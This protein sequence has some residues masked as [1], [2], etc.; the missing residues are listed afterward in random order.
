MKGI[1]PMKPRAGG[2]EWISVSDIM[3]GLM[4][5]FLVV[6]VFFMRQIQQD[7]RAIEEIAIVYD[8][9]R[10]AL[11]ESLFA[12]FRDS[13][14]SWGAEI[15]STTL[16][17]KFG[18]EV[19]FRQGE[20]EI[21]PRFKE[22]LDDFFPRYVAILMQPSFRDHIEE[23]RIEGHTSS[24]W[25]YRGAVRGSGLE[26]YEG[27]MD[28]SQ[29]RTRAVLSYVVR[30]AGVREHWEG[31]LRPLMTANGLSSSQLVRNEDGGE[32]RL[33]SRRVEFRVRTDAERR[34]VEILSMTDRAR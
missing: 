14:A 9:V 8:R 18:P 23:V 5:I 21:Q 6:A 1:I 29:Q 15:D 26:A 27:N 10:D 30:L 17:V 19:L 20:A 32:N 31:W 2:E 24:E 28:L 33:L 13:L 3:S 25:F 22:I 11:Y 4:L 34:M 16:S 7:K 12:E